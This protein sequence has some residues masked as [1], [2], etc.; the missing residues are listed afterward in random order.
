VAFARTGPAR[1]NERE[2]TVKKTILGILA[3]LVLG[4]TAMWFYAKAPHGAEAKEEPKEAAKEPSFIE[5]GTNGETFLKLGKE[6]QARMGLKTAPLAAAQL[7]PEVRGYGR[8]LDPAPLA[9]LL[10]ELASA[11]ASLQ[12]SSSEYD[13]LKLLHQQSQNVSTRALETAEAALKRDQ[14]LLESARLRM[15]VGW[16]KPVADRPDLATLVNALVAREAALVRVD[17]PL[18]EVLKTPPSGARLAPLAAP[19]DLVAAAFLGPAPSTDPQMQGQGF[20]FLQKTNP[21]PPGAA[22]AAWLTF[23]GQPET[24]VNV[25]RAALIRREGEV[26][27]YLQRSDEKFERQEIS[28][29]R[30]IAGGWF[31][32]AGLNPQ[33]K[34]VVVGAQQLLS[35]E[36]KGQSAECSTGIQDQALVG[37]FP[38]LR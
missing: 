15:L 19:E 13:R 27:V 29:V 25:P 6:T 31:V 23:P 18:N 33:D 36:L 21:F 9:A 14:S 17:L 5:H 24:G 16:G 26:F 10:T 4:G 11:K 38:C 22:V 8:V 12:A 3:G 34:V 30:P 28:L 1:G 7:P 35:E 37:A 20:L 32:R 2:Q